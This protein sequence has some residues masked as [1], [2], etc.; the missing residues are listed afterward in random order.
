MTNEVDENEFDNKDQ[1][2][3]VH[4]EKKSGQKEELPSNISD[5]VNWDDMNMRFRDLL[6]EKGLATRLSTNYRFRKD[7]IG[8]HF[9]QT[10]YIREM[11]NGEK[12]DRRWLI[13]SKALD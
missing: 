13:Y 3:V 11:R 4:E 2:E 6:V 1:D 8:R 9:S 7:S 12:Q 10:F 5:P